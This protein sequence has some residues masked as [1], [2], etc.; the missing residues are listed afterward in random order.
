MAIYTRSNGTLQK[1]HPRKLL[2]SQEDDWKR[3]Q[4]AA[5]ALGL[6]WSDFARRAQD[7]LAA[8]VASDT[9]PK[10]K[11]AKGERKQ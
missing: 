10:R 2:E 6:N 3:W 9:P 8:K 7:Q 1:R 4:K 5:D 11:P